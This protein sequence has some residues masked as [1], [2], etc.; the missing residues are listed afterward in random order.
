MSSRVTARRGGAWLELRPDGDG[1]IAAHRGFVVFGD[2][3]A[4]LD[5]VGDGAGRVAVAAQHLGPDLFG[6]R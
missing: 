1:A 5:Y 3:G 4:H 2:P 6:V